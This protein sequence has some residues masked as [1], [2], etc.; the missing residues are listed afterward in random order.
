M[1]ELEFTKNEIME[2][3]PPQVKR[4]VNAKVIDKLNDALADPDMFM[5]MRENLVSYTNVM[6]KGKFSLENY[7]DAVKYISY[8]L[9]GASNLQAYRKTHPDRYHSMKERGLSEKDIASMISAYNKTKLVNLIYEQTLIP[10]WIMNADNLQ[11]AINTQVEIMT[12]ENNSPKVRSDAAN[13]I[14]T[15]IKRP[16]S[17][18]I[19]LDVSHK[20]N[21]A[22][23]DLRAQTSLYV[24]A[25]RELLMKQQITAKEAA[26]SKIQ[27]V[28]A[29][30]KEI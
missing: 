13:S 2:A 28:D 15:H 22:L 14:M 26:H 12:N 17:T 8:K 21:G 25:Q 9:M 16:E 3:L 18:K 6:Q 1:N 11:K 7:I 23:A 24:E 30:Y 29:E 19:E 20:D 10:T 27:A 4:G 5:V